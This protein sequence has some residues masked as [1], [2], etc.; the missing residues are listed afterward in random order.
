MKIFLFLK[1]LEIRKKILKL[2]S[3]NHI[4]KLI[5]PFQISNLFLLRYKEYLK[6]NEN[7]LR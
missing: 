4:N 7:W 1:K 5:F 6:K 3:F 2:K